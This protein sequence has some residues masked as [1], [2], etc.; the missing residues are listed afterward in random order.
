MSGVSEPR[1][2]ASLLLRLALDPVDQAA[3]SEFVDSYGA[4]IYQW[5]RQ[6]TS[7]EADALDVTQTVLLKLAVEM[8]KFRYDQSKSFRG[9]L[10]TLTHN[11]WYQFVTSRQ[12]A[13]QTQG[14][15]GAEERLRSL[16]ARD[17]LVSRLEQQFNL[18]LVEEAS[19]RVQRRVA[20]RTWKAF[21]NR[22]RPPVENES[23]QRLRRQEPGA[24][25]PSRGTPWS[26]AIR[27]NLGERKYLAFQAENGPSGSSHF[28]FRVGWHALEVLRRACW[29]P[30]ALRILLR[31]CHPASEIA[32]V[33]RH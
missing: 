12:S 22:S 8:K 31:A 29:T 13:T 5:C 18:E 4:R 28:G 32:T 9:W 30:H 27:R 19:K 24:E 15:N 26:G 11:A 3:W 17:D 7:Q 20:P 6:Y 33:T 23:C 25:A 10:K 14:S 16:E 21:W 2:H 1:T